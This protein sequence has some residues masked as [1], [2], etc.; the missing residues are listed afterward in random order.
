[1]D[2]IVVSDSMWLNG[3]FLRSSEASIYY[4]IALYITQ[5]AYLHPSKICVPGEI[6][7]DTMY[8]QFLMSFERSISVIFS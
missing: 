4:P 3:I 8:I 7:D 1:M 6:I 5:T 2:D